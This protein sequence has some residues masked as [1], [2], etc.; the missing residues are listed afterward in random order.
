MTSPPMPLDYARVFDAVPSPYLIMTAD[1]VIVTIN[2]AYAE[3]TMIDREAVAGRPMFEVFPDNPADPDADG[4]RNLRRSL[5]TVVDT[6]RADAMAVQRYDIRTPDGGFVVRYWSP[7][8]TPVLADDGTVAFIVHR[9]HDVTELVELRRTG[10]EHRLAA[11]ALQTRVQEMEADLFT[12]GRELQQTNQE[13]QR[14]NAELAAAS[15]DLRAQQQAKDR[16]IATLSHELRN[17]LAAARAALDVL[18][19][20]VSGH[21]ARVVLD[22]QLTALARM[23]DDLL[24]AARIVTGQ[25]HTDRRPLDL[26]AVVEATIG[27]VHGAYPGAS[28]IGVVMPSAPVTVNG[29]PV[30]LAQMLANLLDNAHKHAQSDKPIDLDLTVD[31]GYAVLQVHDAGPGFPPAT[32]A[33]LFDPFVRAAAPGSATP[34]GLGLGLAVVRG[35]AELHDGS[36]AAHS[37]GTDATFTIR[38]P[39]AA[40]DATGGGPAPTHTTRPPLRILLVEDN[41]DLATM[42][43]TLLR[44]RGDTVAV[45]T[46]GTAALA[47][48]RRRPFDLILCDLALGEDIDGYQIARRL[49]RSRTHRHTRLVAVSGFSQVTDRQRSQAAGFDAHLAKPLNPTELDRILA[50]WTNNWTTPLHSTPAEPAHRTD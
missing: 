33:S 28:E 6:A 1:F 3:A 42:Y 48:A 23:T 19:L 9:V 49:R 24:D 32:A 8:N 4:V 39:L 22:R 12:R 38:L 17:P 21:P 35:I 29:D 44:E 25:L 10:N 11:A 50:D 7:V 47:A 31:H 40:A 43:A 46:T 13:L 26:R 20:D 14:V 18:A 2:A 30:R 15:A 41:T 37:T 34:A 27:D 45:A 5:Q 36:A 16:F